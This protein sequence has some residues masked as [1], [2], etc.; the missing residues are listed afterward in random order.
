MLNYCQRSG[1]FLVQYTFV[2]KCHYSFL[3]LSFK[4]K[5]KAKVKMEFILTD[6]KEKSESCVYCNFVLMCLE[7]LCL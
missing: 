6:T 3:L 5:S 7:M 4:R 1:I 2:R